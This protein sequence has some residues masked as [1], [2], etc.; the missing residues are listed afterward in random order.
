MSKRKL[1][2]AAGQAADE[3]FNDS[4]DVPPSRLRRRSGRPFACKGSHEET[5][6]KIRLLA[7][8]LYSGEYAERVNRGEH[9]P[10]DHLDIRDA[11]QWLY[12]KDDGTIGR[13][14]PLRQVWTH[15]DVVWNSE[16]KTLE[17][18]PGKP[19]CGCNPLDRD[20]SSILANP[21]RLKISR[22]TLKELISGTW[23][24]PAPTSPTPEPTL[25]TE[26]ADDSMV[27]QILLDEL[28]AVADEASS[29]QQA[30][31]ESGQPS[32]AQQDEPSSAQQP[33]SSS[34]QHDDAGQAHQAE[35]AAAPQA[36]AHQN[37]GAPSWLHSKLDALRSSMGF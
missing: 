25:A 34:T 15:K 26:N 9:L 4:I 20:V 1:D 6:G 21:E 24:T 32:Q 2:E 8:M 37:S 22:K 31:T 28:A 14:E 35:S 3:E 16:K 27:S 5:K 33:A 13:C 23:F 18:M 36:E 12:M 10:F 7:D 19:S 29:A 30:A 17:F 11:R